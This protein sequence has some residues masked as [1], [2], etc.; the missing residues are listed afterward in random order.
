LIRSVNLAAAQST[1][2]GRRSPWA[3]SARGV[4]VAAGRAEGKGEDRQ[5][6]NDA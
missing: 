5:E 4:V 6:Q 1:L 3:L 2:D